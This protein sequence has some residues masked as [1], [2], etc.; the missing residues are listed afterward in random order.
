MLLSDPMARG[1]QL[2][3]MVYWPKRQGP[4]LRL[5]WRN[6][7]ASLSITRARATYPHTSQALHFVFSETVHTSPA[8]GRGHALCLLACVAT[9]YTVKDQLLFVSWTIYLFGLFFQTFL[10]IITLIYVSCKKLKNTNI[11]QKKIRIPII[12]L[13]YCLEYFF[14]L[15]ILFYVA[16]FMP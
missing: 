11:L 12:P 13:L 3:R 1:A 4:H 15:W 9:Y 16:K 5:H 8:P 6:H 2:D 10:S 14:P 7:R